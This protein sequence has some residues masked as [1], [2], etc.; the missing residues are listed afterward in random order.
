MKITG[1]ISKHNQEDAKKVEKVFKSK[2]PVITY[3][4]IAFNVI[5]YVAPALFGELNN[6]ILDIK[7]NFTSKLTIESNLTFT[8][9]NNNIPKLIDKEFINEYMRNQ[10]IFKNN[11]TEI[12]INTALTL[13][14]NKLQLITSKINQIHDHQKS[15]RHIVNLRM[16]IP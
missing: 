2:F 1:D 16:L 8:I 9:N 7:S 14:E 12:K 3:I 4:L 11:E 5:M 15:C 13:F 6:I 10:I